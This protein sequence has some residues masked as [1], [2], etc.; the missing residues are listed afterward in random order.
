MRSAA[1]VSAEDEL[2]GPLLHDARHQG[3]LSLATIGLH[4]GEQHRHRAD[5]VHGVRSGDQYGQDRD[6]QLP[7]GE[8]RVRDQV[9][10]LQR[11]TRVGRSYV[12]DRDRWREDPVHGGL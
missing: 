10:G 2:Q 8:G 1:L 5:A 6:D 9:L 3:H 4:Q 12:H 7:R 11:R